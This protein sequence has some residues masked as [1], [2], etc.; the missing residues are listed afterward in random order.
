MPFSIAPLGETKVEVALGS[1]R[2]RPSG[3]FDLRPLAQV[4]G[5]QE[6][7]IPLSAVVETGFSKVSLESSWRLAK[8]VESDR[9]DLVVSAKVTNVSS[10]PL[11][12]EAF[13]VADGYTQ[14]RKPIENLQPGQSAVR[15]FHFPAGARRLSGRDVRVGV[16]DSNLDARL[17]KLL[18]IPP[19]VPPSA[20]VGVGD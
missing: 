2:S 19:F 14:N 9:I 3:E 4:S 15:V 13:A 20:V 7:A 11:D 18:P 5:N 12:V 1:P 16:Q 6:H 8:S 10:T 17:L